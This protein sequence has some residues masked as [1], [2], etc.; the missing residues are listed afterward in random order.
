MLV[1]DTGSPGVGDKGRGMAAGLNDDVKEQVKAGLQAA[2]AKHQ[3]TENGKQA[4]ATVTHELEELISEARDQQRWRLTLGAVEAYEVLSPGSTKM[5]R[6]KER[7]QLYI[8]RPNVYVKGFFEDKESKDT[9]VFLDVEVKPSLEH[10][11]VRVRPGDEFENCRL[12][13]FVG[14]KKGVRLEYLAIPGMYWEV[15]GP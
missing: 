12:V 6:L 3:I 11:Q 7:A 2:R 8:L 15:L 10:K 9:Y 13:D 14:D 4:L 1:T 5:N